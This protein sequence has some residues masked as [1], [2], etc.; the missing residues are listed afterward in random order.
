MSDPASDRQA[1]REI[2]E[3]WAIWRDT[4]AWERFR[5]LW[6]DDGEMLATMYQGPVDGFIEQ[7]RR[8][9]ERGVTAQHILG[10]TSVDVAGDRAVAQTRATI[11]QRAV[12][13]DVLCDVVCTI[14]FY[15]FFAKRAGRWGMVRRQGFYEKDRLDPVGPNQTVALDSKRLA[16]F[17]RG[18]CHLAY[19][20]SLGGAAIKPDMPG[21]T[22]PEADD[23]YAKGAAWLAGD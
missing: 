9:H 19:V 11:G 13:H 2:I 20:Q 22:G 23:L 17:P 15:D 4:G 14:R 12:V 21:L 16:Q 18:Y 5:S 6:H 7:A 1:I 10:G 3:N 8:A